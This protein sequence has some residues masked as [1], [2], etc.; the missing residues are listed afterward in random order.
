MP[1]MLF[2]SVGFCAVCCAIA[3]KDLWQIIQREAVLKHAGTR[4]PGWIVGGQ[5]SLWSWKIV[6]SYDYQGKTY[7]NVRRVLAWDLVRKH[8]EVVVLCLPNDPGISLARLDGALSET[9][10]VGLTVLFSLVPG[11]MAFFLMIRW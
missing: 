5:V 11:M 3:V 4:V 8:H 1:F 7:R 6:Y 9:T 10:V 2:A